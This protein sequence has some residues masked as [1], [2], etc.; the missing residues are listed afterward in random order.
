MLIPYKGYSN[1]YIIALCN[2]YNKKPI[3][4][5]T[6]TYCITPLDLYCKN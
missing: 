5:N 1:M 6:Y 3:V 4:Y 2:T